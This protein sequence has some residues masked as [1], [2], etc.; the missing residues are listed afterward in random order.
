MCLWSSREKCQ[1]VVYITDSSSSEEDVAVSDE[2]ESPP[3]IKKKCYSVKHDLDSSDSD[4]SGNSDSSSESSSE[5]SEEEKPK[6]KDKRQIKKG[7][8]E[9]AK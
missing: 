5:S 3:P 1:K 9:S 7:G 2:V 4:I 6:G 8:C